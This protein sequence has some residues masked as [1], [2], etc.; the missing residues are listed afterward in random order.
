MTKT[1][2]AIGNTKPGVVKNDP[3]AD[4]RLKSILPVAVMQLI[5]VEEALVDFAKM[6]M[7]A[8]TTN[9]NKCIATLESLALQTLLLLCLNSLMTSLTTFL[10]VHELS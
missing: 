9:L 7:L 1:K 4:V 2:E 6:M 8:N 10:K 5:P 3:S